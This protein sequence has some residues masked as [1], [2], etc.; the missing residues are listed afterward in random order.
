MTTKPFPR[1]VL[2]WLIPLAVV[3]R[4]VFILV[5]RRLGWDALNAAIRLKFSSVQRI[6]TPGLAAWLKDERRAAPT[7]LD[8]REPAEFD[9]SHL[10]HARQVEPGSDPRALGLPKDAP[11]VTY[12][13]V[14]YRSAEFARRLRQAGYTNVHDLEGSIFQ[15]ANEGRPLV[16]DD[17]QP[18][19]KV[20]PFNKTWGLLLDPDRRANVPPSKET[21]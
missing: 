7:L 18:A 12:C 6:Q 8:V 4:F 2:R 11:I 21:P 14:G 10:A 19:E 13:S 3:G 1:A 5:W 20:H 17:R 15:W 9:V 16:K